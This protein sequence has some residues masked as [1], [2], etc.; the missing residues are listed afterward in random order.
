MNSRLPRKRL[1]LVLL[2]ET[3]KFGREPTGTLSELFDVH[4][5]VSENKV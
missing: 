4:L 3:R 1:D 2:G 5:A